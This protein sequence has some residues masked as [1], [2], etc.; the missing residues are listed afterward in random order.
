MTVAARHV[1]LIRPGASEAQSDDTF[2]VDDCFGSELGATE[3]YKR[4]LHPVVR[5]CVD[6]YNSALLTVG[7]SGS[8]KS[9]ILHGRNGDGTVRL[10][11]KALFEALHNKS[12]Q[13]GTQLSQHKASGGGGQAMEFAV[14]A[15]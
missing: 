7:C 3:A 12:A 13:V 6:G 9:T 8:G 2:E 1:A 4:V 11:I 14:D 10:A 5:Q 15:S